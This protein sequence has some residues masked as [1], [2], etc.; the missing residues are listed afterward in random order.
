MSTPIPA[1]TTGTYYATITTNY[2]IKSD[3]GYPLA[4]GG[5]TA[6]VMYPD[7]DSGGGGGG[8]GTTSNIITKTYGD[9]PFDLTTVGLPDD[10]KGKI[11][12]T[13]SDDKILSIKGS[14][15]TIRRS[16]TVRIT[17]SSSGDVKYQSVYGSVTIEIKPARLIVIAN[18]KKVVKGSRMPTFTYYTNG[19][20]YNDTFI[21]P[22]MTTT[23]KDTNT[24]GTY[25]INI[26]GG[27]PS[28]PS[29][30]ISY[31][32]GKLRIVDEDEEADTHNNDGNSNAGGDSGN[33][34]NSSDGK[35]SGTDGNTSN[36]KNS[37]T[38]GNTS[39]GKNSGTGGQSKKGQTTGSRSKPSASVTTD[40]T[41]TAKHSE[42]TTPDKN[43]SSDE[44]KIAQSSF[45]PTERGIIIIDNLFFLCII[46]W[47]LLI[48]LFRRKK[49]DNDDDKQG[50]KKI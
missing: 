24:I 28:N 42:I 48:I 26:Y 31:Q 29:Y 6:F 27:A 39:S 7:N 23:A 45:V 14:T 36:G 10:A 13:S 15:A 38:G 44:Q 2:G 16:G 30:I 20:K 43:P 32:K 18:D 41:T 4:E 1:S 37:G 11:T 46:M 34:S 8:G 21:G 12:Y 25:D 3:Y 35:S 50:A 19:L 33:T 17:A 47:L 49:K 22:T 9:P 5:V 40:G